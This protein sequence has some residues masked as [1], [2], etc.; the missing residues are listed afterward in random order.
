MSKK[1]FNLV[2]NWKAA[3]GQR[4]WLELAVPKNE[5]APAEIHISGTI[6]KN[7]WDDSGTSG[8]EF[9]DALNTVPK[10]QKINVRINSEGGSVQDGLEIYNA[11]KERSA[12]VTSHI[13][14]YAVSIASVIPLAASRVISPTSSV[15]MIHEPW[16]VTQGDASEHEKAA[17]MLDKHGDMLAQIYSDETGHSKKE[18]REA[19][20]KETWFTGEE[21][22]DFGLADETSEEDCNNALRGLAVNN[23]KPSP[24]VMNL[25]S[26]AQAS[27]Q[28]KPKHNEE[29]MNKK[30]VVALLE[31]ARH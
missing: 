4:V 12:D 27:G 3:D 31:K 28:P 1:V 17:E 5:T 23:F 19:M 14:G 2:K 6:G 15:W 10:G 18:M 9:R 25:I 11:I 20:K 26:A 13:S 16:S 24:A 8:K 21:A 7:W 29:I 30:I 22:C